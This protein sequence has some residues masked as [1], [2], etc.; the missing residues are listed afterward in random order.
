MPPSRLDV[1]AAVFFEQHCLSRGGPA[2]RCRTF[3]FSAALRY[4]CE[5]TAYYRQTHEFLGFGTVIAMYPYINVAKRD[6]SEKEN[7]N[8]AAFDLGERRVGSSRCC[9]L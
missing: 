2:S 8:E 5:R 3:G 7:T 4:F 6:A 1:S 9:G